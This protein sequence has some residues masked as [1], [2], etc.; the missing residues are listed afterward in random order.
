MKMETA[1]EALPPRDTGRLKKRARV[2]AVVAVGSA[3]S[4]ERQHNDKSGRVIYSSAS[5]PTFQ[6]EF[7]DHTADVQLH[8]CE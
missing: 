8:A 1:F 2:D 7:L 5:S 6:Y 4:G 3:A